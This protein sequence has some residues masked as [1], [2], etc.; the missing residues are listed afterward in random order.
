MRFQ[1][2]RCIWPITIL[3][4]AQRCLQTW[5]RWH[6]FSYWTSSNAPQVK[7]VQEC[8][9]GLELR[10]NDGSEVPR[11]SV[12]LL[13]V[14][15]GS[16]WGG[17][18]DPGDRLPLQLPLPWPR[19]WGEGG[20]QGGPASLQTPY[21]HR[22]S[23]PC[24]CRSTCSGEV[25]K[26][27]ENEILLSDLP[28]PSIRSSS[29]SNANNSFKNIGDICEVF[30]QVRYFVKTL[31]GEAR[32]PSAVDMEKDREVNPVLLEIEEKKSIL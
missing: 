27:V 25:V 3:L 10:L 11:S 31:V 26:L 23:H 5:N 7:G 24:L 22:P 32:L 4:C 12:C 16:G 29:R 20:E 15:P 14:K 18:C 13:L 2:I 19:V 30:A 8:G 28:L 6:Y 9:G 17:G 21:Q 1:C